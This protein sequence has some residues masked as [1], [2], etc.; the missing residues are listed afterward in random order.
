MNEYLTTEECDHIREIYQDRSIEL[1]EHPTSRG[2]R[3]QFL[4]HIWRQSTADFMGVDWTDWASRSDDDNNTRSLGLLP[5]PHELRVVEKIEH[6]L[7]DFKDFIPKLKDNKDWSGKLYDVWFD[8]K[9]E[10]RFKLL[11]E[12]RKRLKE[13]IPTIEKASDDQRP[14]V[15]PEHLKGWKE[16]CAA[17]EV[18]YSDRERVRSSNI[19]FAG[20]I[21]IGKTGKSPRAE[22]SQLINWWDDL[23]KVY[24]ASAQKSQEQQAE[25]RERQISAEAQHNYGRDGIVATEIG[26]SIHQSRSSVPT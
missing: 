21:V 18:K 14:S 19:E 17:V 22:K 15:R 5:I 10:C 26:G 3:Q 20:P 1:D 23:H 8:L 6:F 4:D 11:R 9:P 25:H 7:P 2:T 12:A 16:I 13:V 24:Q